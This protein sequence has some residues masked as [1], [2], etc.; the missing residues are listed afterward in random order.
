MG[1]R[2][3]HIETL[4]SRWMELRPRDLKGKQQPSEALVLERWPFGKKMQGSWQCGCTDA[5]VS[6]FLRRSTIVFVYEYTLSLKRKILGPT[7]GRTYENK[8]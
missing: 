4:N 3:T 7:W 8:I 6:D 2:D 5:I 1:F